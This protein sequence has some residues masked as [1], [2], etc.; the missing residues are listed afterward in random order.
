MLRC[1]CSDHQP[2]QAMPPKTPP[3]WA[4]L[5]AAEYLAGVWVEGISEQQAWDLSAAAFRETLGWGTG[6]KTGFKKYQGF[7]SASGFGHAVVKMFKLADQP[8]R[9]NLRKDYVLP[10][11]KKELI[12]LHH[13]ETLL[14]CA[15]RM[16]GWAGEE[17][18]VYPMV[19]VI[20]TRGSTKLNWFVLLQIETLEGTVDTAIIRVQ[21]LTEQL[22]A[23]TS[24]ADS[25]KRRRVE[26]S[27]M[28]PTEPTQLNQSDIDNL[29]KRVAR[30][31]FPPWKCWA[32]VQVL[33][34]V[35]AGLMVVEYRDSSSWGRTRRRSKWC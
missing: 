7:R 2:V 25:V 9:G 18:V 3:H 5:A 14:E 10:H 21:Q 24:P 23:A 22:E 11:C 13:G 8:K 33:L 34:I 20:A 28:E 4:A 32:L 31:A 19:E 6:G 15:D 16:Q 27:A 1:A 30:G 17:L 12:V 35:C 29:T 26:T